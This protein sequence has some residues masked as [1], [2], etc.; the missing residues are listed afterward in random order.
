MLPLVTRV[1]AS[2][3][4]WLG[5]H[6]GAEVDLKPDLDQVAALAEERDQHW[7]RVAS[8]DF[9]TQAEKRAAL[10]LPPLAEG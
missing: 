5:E 8:A 6:L 3:A 10:G 2:V 4:W 1:S 9:L 7:R